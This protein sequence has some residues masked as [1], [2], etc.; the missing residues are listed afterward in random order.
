M[1]DFAAN[2]LREQARAN[3]LSPDE[4][5]DRAVRYYLSERSS[6]RLARKLPGFLETIS[7]GRC[8]AL[9]VDL[10]E[11]AWEE[12]EGVAAREG[13]SVERVLEHAL[14]LLVADLD[15]G[16][17]AARF[18]EDASEQPLGDGL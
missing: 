3:A 6:R 17:V 2:T 16:R 12:L 11:A 1:G 7:N 8:I 4:F 18:V 9:D 5:L 10:E 15:S 14:L 13:V